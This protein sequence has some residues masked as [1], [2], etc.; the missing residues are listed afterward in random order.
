MNAPTEAETLEEFLR[1][2]AVLVRAHAK[3]EEAEAR[4]REA[5]KELAAVC[6]DHPLR[7]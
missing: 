1:K 6:E 7:D 5:L 3:V 4:Y 2:R